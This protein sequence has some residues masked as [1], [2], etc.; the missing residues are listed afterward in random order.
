MFMYIE[1]ET[2]PNYSWKTRN[3]GKKREKFNEL[4]EI[5][6][7]LIKKQSSRRIRADS[8]I[9]QFSETPFAIELIKRQ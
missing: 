7:K 6:S 5:A 1:A 8:L 2:T 9:S 4:H 3:K